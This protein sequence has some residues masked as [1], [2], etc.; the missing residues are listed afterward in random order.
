MWL[1]KR[2]AC[3][4]SRCIRTIR[5]TDRSGIWKLKASQIA[6]MKSKPGVWFATHQDVAAYV[7]RRGDGGLIVSI[8]STA[9]LSATPLFRRRFRNCIIFGENWA[10]RSA[11][12]EFW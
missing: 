3:T 4:C 1:T 9:S 11:A 12:L 2:A 5:D 7:K 10:A 8:G 6:Y